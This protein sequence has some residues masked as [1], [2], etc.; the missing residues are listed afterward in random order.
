MRNAIIISPDQD[1]DDLQHCR[2]MIADGWD[3]EEAAQCCGLEYELVPEITGH[4][5]GDE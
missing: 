2:E 4:A 1:K 5:C 3:K